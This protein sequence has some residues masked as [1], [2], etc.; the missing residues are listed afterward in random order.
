MQ[1]SFGPSA[2]GKDAERSDDE[3]IRAITRVKAAKAGSLGL[4]LALTRVWEL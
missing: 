4:I 2:N 1:R 3:G